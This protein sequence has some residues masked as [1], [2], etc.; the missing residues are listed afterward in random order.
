VKK[1]SAIRLTGDEQ[2]TCKNPA[3]KISNPEEL[4]GIYGGAIVGT[5]RHGKPTGM[6]A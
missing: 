6:M 5:R 2:S 4:T 1:N 3:C